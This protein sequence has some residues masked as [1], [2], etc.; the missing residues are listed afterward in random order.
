MRKNA[1]SQLIE[2]CAVARANYMLEG[3]YAEGFIQTLV[4]ECMDRLNEVGPDLND[5]S[6]FGADHDEKKRMKLI[7]RMVNLLVKQV[8]L[9]AEMDHLN[10]SYTSVKIV[11]K[12]E[13]AE[14]VNF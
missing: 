5:F 10:H 14:T 13:T 12:A 11:N 8:L 1:T 2:T 7:D 9:F 3:L 4:N 6:W